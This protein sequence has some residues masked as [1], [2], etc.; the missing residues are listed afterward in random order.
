MLKMNRSLFVLFDTMLEYIHS[1]VT[2]RI[3]K[4]HVFS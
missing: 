1:T 3:Q 4:I 2:F